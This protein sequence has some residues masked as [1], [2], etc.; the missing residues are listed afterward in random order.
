M[1][2]SLCKPGL[3]YIVIIAE[4]P[5]A[6]ERIAKALGALRK[7]T[8]N[9]I[10]YWV[11]SVDGR[12]VFVVS[13]AGHLFEPYTDRHDFPV[14]EFV[15]KPIWEVEPSSGYL[16]RFYDVLKLILPKASEYI[17]AC[18]YDIEGSVIC[19]KII[20]ALGDIRRAKRMKFSTL[21]PHDVRE[22][23]RKLQPLDIEMVEAGLAR[24][25]LDWLWGINVSRA[26]MH[27]IKVYSGKRVILSAGRVQSPTLVEAVR[28]WEE[29]NLHVPKPS[30]SLS[31]KLKSRRGERF[32]AYPLDWNPKSRREAEEVRRRLESSKT[33]LVVSY[34]E[35]LETIKPPP[36]FNLGEL[37]HEA[38]RIYGFSPMKTQEIA[39]QLYLEALISYPRTNSQKLP[40]TINYASIL[41]SLGRISEYSSLVKSLLEETRGV[42]K[43][44]QGKAEDPAHPAIYPTGEKPEDLTRE[45][46]LIYDLIV[47][48]FLAAFAREA[49]IERVRVILRDVDGRVYESRGLR[50]TREGWM[51]YYPFSKPEE[52]VV[53]K[54]TKGERVDVEGVVTKVTWSK[55]STRITKDSLL[56]WME[57][58]EI[59]TEATRARIIETLYKRGYII[60]EGRVSKVTDLGYTVARV[61]QELFP[62]LATPELTREFERKLEDIRYGRR[63]RDSVR[64][65]AIVTLKD[66]LAKY[67][68]RLNDVGRRLAVSL[69]LKS[70]EAPCDVCGRESTRYIGTLRLCEY[71][72]KALEKLRESIR[73]VATVL[74]ISEDE[75]LK[76]IA[77][78]KGSTGRWV[79][80]LARKLMEDRRLRSLVLS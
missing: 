43:P 18:D 54:L 44:V 19:Y 78:K 48:R 56:E 52:V 51:R 15:W 6:G 40:P 7:C 27:A 9:K 28:R 38:A 37:Q 14:F 3:G 69:G 41:A 79:S 61:I 53:P 59:G 39:E 10:P 47:R 12:R 77:S 55:P 50:V 21:T 23:F 80:E 36:A 17:S 4:K 1:S 11:L 45:Q 76:V 24:H 25:E 42:L 74:N 2:D 65:E 46:A 5:R 64:R 34:E 31:I 58:V 20:E 30:M 33:L 75:A 63:S 35:E 71:H 22:A 29:L 57:R 16:K 68:M 67:N 49:V 73:V 66:L 70:P 62:E 32:N 13:S 72:L 60:Q 26:L 8:H